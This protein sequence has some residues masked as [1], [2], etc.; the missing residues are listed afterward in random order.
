MTQPSPY[1][2]PNPHPSNPSLAQPGLVTNSPFTSEHVAGV[3]SGGKGKLIGILAGVVVVIVALGG[4]GYAFSKHQAQQHDGLAAGSNATPPPPVSNVPDPKV[5]DA[6]QTNVK[7]EGKPAE[8]AGSTTAGGTTTQEQPKNDGQTAAHA[9][10]H[11]KPGTK[12][13]PA[14]KPAPQPVA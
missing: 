3:P 4:A 2:T 6:V 11:V 9:D 7:P 14:P 8:S 12:P 5:V 10:S 13:A 1:Q